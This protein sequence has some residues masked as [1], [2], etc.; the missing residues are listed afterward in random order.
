MTD[1]STSGLVQ[2]WKL[3]LTSQI[4]QDIKVRAT[5][6]SDIR[7]P[8]VGELFAGAL[9]S[10]QTVTYPPGAGGRS[11]NVRFASPGNPDPGAR[12][13]HHGFGR[14]RA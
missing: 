6:S 9:I 14:Y 5:Y 2:T 10:T 4:N 8:S 1:Y 12:T 3:G 13:I 11:F 7:A